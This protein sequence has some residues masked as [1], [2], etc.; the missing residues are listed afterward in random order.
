MNQLKTVILLAA[1]GGLLVVLGGYLGGKN[2]ATIAFVIA[3]A[4]NVGSYWFSDRIVL[5][6]YHAQ[7]VTESE[8][9]DLYRMI[10]NLAQNAELPMP[11]VYIIPDDSPNAFATGRNPE[12]AAVA[13]T[14]GIL[15]LLNKDELAGVI[16]H[17]LGHVKNR[18]ILIQ[19]V[20]ATIGTAITYLAHFGFFFGGRSDDDRGGGSFVG[21]ILM[22]ILAP[23]AAAVIQMAISR[24][25]EY[26]ADDT[27]AKICG[28]PL[29]LASALGKLQRGSEAIPMHG[30][31]ATA[32]MFIVSP[33]FGGGLSSLFS[34]HP[35][36]ENRVERLEKMA[37]Y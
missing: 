6:M 22:M 2:G 33:F 30:E 32:H 9:P 21:S 26:I 11:K 10:R 36:I 24:S 20:A 31:Q 35:P 15:R 34:T 3:L 37:G 28:H 14:E 7:E 13:V 25:R 4:M 27:G 23:M 5:S 19:T 12:H 17:E 16:G 8:A 29:W 1:L 18:D